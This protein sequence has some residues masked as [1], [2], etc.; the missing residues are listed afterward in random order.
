MAVLGN[1]TRWHIYW[2]I[3]AVQLYPHAY[4]LLVPSKTICFV[5]RNDLKM[6]IF[7]WGDMGVFV[8]WILWEHLS[9]NLDSWYLN[10]KYDFQDSDGFCHTRELKRLWLVHSEGSR[11]TRWT[12]R[13][14]PRVSPI[15][16][17]RLVPVSAHVFRLTLKMMT[18]N[19]TPI[20]WFFFFCG[21]P[22]NKVY[23]HLWDILTL[24]KHLFSDFFFRNTCQYISYNTF[25]STLFF[26]WWE[27]FFL[28]ERV[29][30][31]HKTK[32]WDKKSTCAHR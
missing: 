19:S 26:F 28:V 31:K 13:L 11:L 10:L 2:C 22:K 14:N 25:W 18:E 24:L 21:S 20:F 32:A 27:S 12:L 6:K 9:T 8:C 17:Y 30:P 4:L 23:R 7:F 16:N 29:A 5:F 15:F 1:N 3:F